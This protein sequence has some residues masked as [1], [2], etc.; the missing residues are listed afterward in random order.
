MKIRSQEPLVLSSG[1]RYALTST[2]A[3]GFGIN[4]QL[5]R[6]NAGYGFDGIYTGN[7][8]VSVGF[9]GQP[10]YDG[11][12]DTYYNVMNLLSTTFISHPPAPELWICQ[13]THI[14]RPGMHESTDLRR[15]KPC[16]GHVIS[17]W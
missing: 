5:E 11:T 2:D 12:S 13:D 10:L 15:A 7:R 16:V 8:M 3:I 9:R 1:N 4:F 14:H 17:N 6:S